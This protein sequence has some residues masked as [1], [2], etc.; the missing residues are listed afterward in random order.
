M[1]AA[2]VRKVAAGDKTEGGNPEDVLSNREMEVFQLLGEGFGVRKIAEN[3][4]ISVKTVEAHRE[5][6]KQK[7]NF[8]SSSEL[9]RYAIQHAIKDRPSGTGDKPVE[10]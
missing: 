4:F 6:I 10:G 3:L 8:K 7:M 5:H 1:A 9:L 2:I